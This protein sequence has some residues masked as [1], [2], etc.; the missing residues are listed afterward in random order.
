VSASR[1]RLAGVAWLG[2]TALTLAALGG[3]AS[4]ARVQ[5]SSPAPMM[6]AA[7]TPLAAPFLMFRALAPARVHDRVAMRA[8]GVRDPI[9]AV[10]PLTCAR[11]HFGGGRGLCLVEEAAA[12]AT[13]HVAFV[14]DRR[15]RRQHRIPLAGVPTR[16]R[17]SPDGRLAAVSTYAEE[18]SPAGERLAL[19]SVLI[20]TVRGVVL[21]DLRDFTVDPEGLVGTP[22][23]FSSVAFDADGD[24][25]YATLSTPDSRHLVVGSARAR[26]L[27]A[28]AA[29]MANEALS[30][31]GRR[32]IVKRVNDRGF[33]QLSILDLASMTEQHLEHQMRSI[34]DQVEWLDDGSVIFHDAT[35]AGTGIWRLT[36]DGRSE[37]QLLVADAYSPV[38]VR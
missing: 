23:D 17:V 10:T 5:A 32:L 22:R 25:F 33:W 29:G 12:M 28:I 13:R 14:F 35:G 34:D 8:L 26:R 24:R 18:E 38:V 4:R 11:V 6:R 36:A 19:E 7:R 2:M 31:D 37:P 30:P 9:L 15:F 16:V 3:V 1:P 20:D 21:A 27:V